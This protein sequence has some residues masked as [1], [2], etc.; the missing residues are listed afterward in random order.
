MRTLSSVEA[1]TVGGG[2][3]GDI[4]AGALPM[5]MGFELLFQALRDAAETPPVCETEWCGEVTLR[6]LGEVFLA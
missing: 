2:T 4:D 5:V 3:G 1:A 6:S